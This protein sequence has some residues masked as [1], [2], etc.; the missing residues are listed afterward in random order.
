[1]WKRVSILWQISWCI[2]AALGLVLIE[3]SG[4]CAQSQPPDE[5]RRDLNT[6][7]PEL[8]TFHE[9]SF[10]NF[11]SQ[12]EEANLDLAAHRY[13]IPIAQMQV[14]AAHIYPDPVIDGLWGGDIS[15]QAQPT[16]YAANLSQTILLGGKIGARTAVAKAGVALA[17]AQLQDFLLELKEQAADT[18]IDGLCEML[19]LQRKLKGLQRSQ[20]L[21]RFMRSELGQGR[22]G[23][24]DLLRARVSALQDRNNLINAQSNLQHTIVK[25]TVLMGRHGRVDMVR[26]VGNLDI[27]P[28]D[29]RLEALVARALALRSEIAAARATL[30]IARAQYQLA[31]ANQVPDLNIGV[32]YNHFTQATNPIDPSP[33][34]N[35]LA[36][37]LS[38]PI[39]LSNL[40]PGPLQAARFSELQAEKALQATQLR[41]ETDVRGAYE[42]YD[43]AI[44]N[45]AQY[46]KELVG[47]ANK[48]YKAKLYS[49][50]KGQTS[51]LDVL[52]AH[53]T[54]DEVY[55]AYYDALAEQAKALVAVEHASAMWDVNF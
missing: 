53:R 29:F 17:S 22:M 45:V 14:L 28:R 3:S 44:D 40:N 43:I 48:V 36:L 20:E 16:T 25:M 8:E 13:N 54:I 15:H 37:E 35:A 4:A 38:L 26:P 51:L 7:F 49:L 32:N 9:I 34:W 5:P 19:K 6:L 12:V 24:I 21:I 11:I 50:E 30:D 55:I 27:P 52:D 31:Q 39:P 47:D 18:Y 1:M 46:A 2:I 23:E 42:R 41:V 33:A 10:R